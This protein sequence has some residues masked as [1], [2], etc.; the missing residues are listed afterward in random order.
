MVFMKSGEIRK[1]FLQY[2]SAKAHQIVPSA[3]M[4]IKNDPTL[5]FTNAGMNQFKDIFLGNSPV[6]Y[7]RVANTQKCLRVSG[8]HNDLEEVGHDT[9]H[10]TMF[11]MLGNWSFGDYFKKEAIEWAWEFL[12]DVLG[13]NADNLYATVFEGSPEEGI[14]FDA[15]AFEC[16]KR[17]LPEE[18]ILRGNKKDNFWEMGDTGPCGPCSEV[19]VD[20][21]PE[22]ERRATPGREMVNK[23]HPQVIEIWNLVFIQYNRKLNGQLELLPARHVDTGMGFERLAMVVQGKR[24]N[25][26]TD[27]F[28]P[29]INKISWMSGID[30]GKDPQCDVAMRV[31]ADHLRAVSFSIADGQLPSNV[32]AGYVIR[33]ILRRAVRYGY[34]FLNFRE[35]FINNLVNVLVDEMGAF[36]PELVAQKELITKVIHE[37]EASFLR[38]LDTGIRLLDGRIEE[39]KRN[40]IA[41]ISGSDAFVLYDTFGFPLDLTELILRENGLT[42]NRAEFDRAMAAQKER[43]RS[44]AAVETHDWQVLFDIDAVEFVGY[45][46]LK[47]EVRIARMRTVKVK[48]KEQYQ[49]VFDKTPFYAESGGQ[50]G[51]TGTIQENGETIQILNTVKENNLTIHIADKLPA[52]P[53]AR[54]YAKVNVEHRTST[55]NNHSATHLLHN[56]L[57]KVLGTHVEQKGSL[58]HPDYLRFD[59]AHFQK[60]TDEEIRKVEMHVNRAIR[61]NI[62]LDEHRDVPMPHAMQMGAM[63]LFGEKYGESVRVIRF[64]ESVELCGGTHVAATGQI[65]FFKITSES[66]ISAGVRRIEAIT[67]AKAEEFV[68]AQA[69][70]IKE[71]KQVLGN[72]SNLI[73]GAAKLVEENALLRKDI[74]QLMREKMQAVKLTLKSKVESKNGINVI[75]SRVDISNAEAIKDMAFQLRNEVEKLFLVLGSESEGKAMLTLM[76]SDDLVKNRNFNAASIIRDAAREIQGGGGGQPFYATAGGKNPAG[77]DAAIQKAVSA[78]N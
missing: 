30:Y 78:V 7:P 70:S 63:A 55:A 33:R 59:F 32:K 58:V 39:A 75:A 19:H 73:Q 5:M 31:V 15:E 43:S 66:A 24:S 12:V 54:F 23:G 44:D 26:D 47:T 72:P 14:D 38:T 3:P 16:W 2:F 28:Q 49:L 41:E 71:L 4:V 1:A 18:R 8:K 35:P 61:Q 34:T 42:V 29:I 46:T 56:A 74:E 9:Y 21:R 48:G 68:Y 60:M 36:F 64:G 57:R 52:K 6:K 77:L 27:V 13:I 17:F 65:G 53:E 69:D 62:D 22:E 11:E 40:R 37:E 25:Y 45:D 50:V 76:I 51:D 20:I 10:H 67:G